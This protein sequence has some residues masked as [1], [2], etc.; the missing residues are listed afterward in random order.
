MENKLSAIEWLENELKKQGFLYDLD[1]EV[2]KDM[3]KKEIKNAYESGCTGEVFEL[4]CNESAET[5]YQKNYGN[6]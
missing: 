3:H 5:Y 2:A 1:L 4:N 6:Q